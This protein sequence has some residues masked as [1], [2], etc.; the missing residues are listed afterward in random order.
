MELSLTGRL[1]H[2]E[3]PARVERKNV[4]TAAASPKGQ[5]R[6]DQVSLSKQ[7]V[8]YLE[9]QRRLSM[10]RF[11]QEM[12]KKAREEAEGTS[13]ED[14]LDALG[15]AL[16]AMKKCQEIAARIMRGDRVPP[17]DERYLMESDPNGYKLAIAMR[18][19]KKDPKE[20]D[21]ILD[22]EDQNGGS[23]DSGSEGAGEAGEAAASSEGTS[24]GGAGGETAGGE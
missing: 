1:T 9:E 12:A 8:E 14:K 3:Q 22:D 6:A 15:K 18:T 20:W 10:E 19:P 16:E 5:T 23:G 7:A 11:E 2:T 21:S 17:E 24:S 4:S 13:E